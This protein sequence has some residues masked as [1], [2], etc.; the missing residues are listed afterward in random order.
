MLCL[1]KKQKIYLTR[2]FL[3][4][5]AGII[6]CFYLEVFQKYDTILFIIYWGGAFY[7]IAGF[8]LDFN[9]KKA[10]AQRRRL[11]SANTYNNILAYLNILGNM[12]HFILFFI[13]IAE[14]RDYFFL[15]KDIQIFQ[16]VHLVYIILSLLT[17]IVYFFLFLCLLGSIFGCINLP[18]IN[19]QLDMTR[20]RIIGNIQTLTMIHSENTITLNI[21][22]TE[23]L[24]TFYECY[25]C[26]ERKGNCQTLPCNHCDICLECVSQIQN[27]PQCRRR[28]ERLIINEP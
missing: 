19:R 11:L 7:N 25:I 8:I 15:F 4:I 27:C 5:I 1:D 14:Y 22:K 24:D 17:Y 18:F 21:K 20:N 26:Y 2:A 6:Q 23:T 12:A 28:I 3:Y 13:A 16:I 9:Y 10:I